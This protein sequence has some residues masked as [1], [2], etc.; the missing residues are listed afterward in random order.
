MVR[1]VRCGYS[2]VR[3]KGAGESVTR[4]SSCVLTLHSGVKADK[5]DYLSLCASYV[6]RYRCL[7]YEY[8]L[9]DVAFEAQDEVANLRRQLEVMQRQQRVEYDLP[10]CG[11]TKCEGECGI[12]LL[13]YLYWLQLRT[14]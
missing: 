11:S 4:A 5:V 1:W 2:A 13:A 10:I 7:Y 6:F 14:P 12:A 8:R 3:R 9:T